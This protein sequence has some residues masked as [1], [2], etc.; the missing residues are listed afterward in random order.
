[1]NEQGEKEEVLRQIH[2][3]KNHLVDKQTFFPYNYN[4]IYIWSL[5][6]LILTLFAVD[7][8][9]MSM[10]KGVVFVSTLVITGF[11]VE[12][13]MTKKVNRSYDIEEC[14]LR[15]QFIMKNFVML[16]LFMI[17]LGSILSLYKLYAVMFLAWLFLVSLGYFAVG[18]VLNIRRFTYMA[19]FNM[20]T[21][22]ILLV[23]GAMKGGLVGVSSQYLHVTQL[24]MVVGVVIMPAIVA[25]K[26]NQE[27]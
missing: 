1:M 14:T 16:S 26:Q 25:W 21:A 19:K 13:M 4:A 20:L 18:F 12:G 22:L 8:Y 27:V 23:I 3:I 9:E 6:T 17:V 5:I 15:Q 24:F 11:V 7:V 10:I 2:E